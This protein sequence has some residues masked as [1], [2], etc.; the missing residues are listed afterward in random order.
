M[1]STLETVSK[2][3]APQKTVRSIGIITGGGDCPGLNA[4]IRAAVKCAVLKYGWKVTG[5]QDGFDGLIWPGKS[6]PLGLSDVSGILPRGGTV[7]GTTNRGNPFKY[8]LVEDGVEVE[9]DVSGRLIKNFHEL[10][11]DALIVIGGDGTQKIALE[12]FQMG[13]NVVGVP[14][15]IDNDISATEVTFG[16]D[17]ALHTATDAIDKIHTTAESHHRIMVVEVMGR[18]AGWIALEAGIAG[19]AHVILIPEIPFTIQRVCEFVQQRSDSGKRFTIIVVAEGAKMPVDF[20]TRLGKERRKGPR[21]RSM[22]S[23]IGDA[24]AERIKQEIRVTVLGHIQRGGSPSPF[25]RILSTRFGVAAVDLVAR[26]E[27]G[28]MVCLRRASV[29]SVD[30][31]QAIG[32]TNVV[33]PQ[34]ELVRTA[35]STGISFGD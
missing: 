24:V 12:L 26:G 30:I 25:D 31:A 3:V 28:K 7:L 35:K 20:S 23:L 15:T 5:I 32:M 33:D 14:K 6:R 10:G 16:F 8:R 34:G 27:F 29:D 2:K 19:G 11:L 1:Q 21:P 17:T 13:V 4:V 18:D 22:G 9:R